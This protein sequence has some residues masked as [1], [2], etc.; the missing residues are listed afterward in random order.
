M[1]QQEKYHVG[2]VHKV[3][4]RRKVQLYID[5]EFCELYRIQKFILTD[6]GDGIVAE[7]LSPRPHRCLVKW[8]K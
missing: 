5:A 7:N 2:R 1:Q 4:K 8:A 3:R 6:H